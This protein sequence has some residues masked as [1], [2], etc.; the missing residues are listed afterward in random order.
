MRQSK[1]VDSARLDTQ[2][3]AG[4]IGKGRKKCHMYFKSRYIH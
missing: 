1:T 3:Q 4:S 2:T